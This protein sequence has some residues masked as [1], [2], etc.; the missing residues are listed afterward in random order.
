MVEKK[1]PIPAQHA[2][3]EVIAEINAILDTFSLAT[4]EALRSELWAKCPQRSLDMLLRL[5]KFGS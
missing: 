2:K 1:Y 5:R 4:L 3:P